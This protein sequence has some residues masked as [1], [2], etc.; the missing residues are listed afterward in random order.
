MFAD[1]FG[2][3]FPIDLSLNVLFLIKMVNDKLFNKR[4]F[5]FFFLKDNSLCFVKQY[6][7]TC[8]RFSRLRVVLLMLYGGTKA[9]LLIFCKE[10]TSQEKL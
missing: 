2:H 6:I 3:L 4:F 1:S 9:F 10:S 7:C 5:F 8:H